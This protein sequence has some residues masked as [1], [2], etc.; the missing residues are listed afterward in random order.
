MDVHQ[1]RARSVDVGNDTM[2]AHWWQRRPDVVLS[3]RMYLEAV[4]CRGRDATERGRVPVTD[5]FDLQLRQIYS[6]A[7]DA[8]AVGWSFEPGSSQHVEF[9]YAVAGRMSVTGD[10]YAVI[11]LASMAAMCDGLRD[12]ERWA[13]VIRDAAS[14]RRFLAHVSNADPFSRPP[15]S[16]R[17]HRSETGNIPLS[18]IRRYLSPA[19][20]WRVVNGE[21]LEVA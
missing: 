6:A 7:C 19:N 10:R 2:K 3:E 13:K 11:D 4:L 5:L 21:R 18:S 1:G 20:R 12:V 9:L 17:A 16:I 14:A 15:R 8:I